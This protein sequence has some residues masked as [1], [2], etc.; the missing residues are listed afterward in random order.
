MR[1]TTHCKAL[2]RSASGGIF[3]SGIY[4]TGTVGGTADGTR[5][6]CTA[7]YFRIRMIHVQWL[8]LLFVS[9]QEN[10]EKYIKGTLRYQLPGIHTSAGRSTR[11]EILSNFNFA[12]RM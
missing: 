3:L 6:K 11:N 2:G 12:T 10:Q 5:V 8:V 4:N 1:E 9:K 7:W